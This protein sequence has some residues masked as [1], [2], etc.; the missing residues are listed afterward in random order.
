MSQGVC[1]RKRE[2]DREGEREGERERENLALLHSTCRFSP[3]PP[4]TSQSEERLLGLRSAD[5]TMPAGVVSA[6][7]PVS[8]QAGCPPAG[9]SY[10]DPSPRGVGSAY[11]R[12]TPPQA[13]GRA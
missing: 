2:R 5:P 9:R 13:A 4:A 8:R 10:K 12:R 3:P 1:V 7:L 11:C 6:A